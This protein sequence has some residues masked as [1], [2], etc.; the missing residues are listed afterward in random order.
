MDGIQ[1]LPGHTA[2][3]YANIG[4]IVSSREAIYFAAYVRDDDAICYELRVTC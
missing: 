4:V 1:P 3:I 2:L